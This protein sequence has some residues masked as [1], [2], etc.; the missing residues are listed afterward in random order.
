M[1]RASERT[2]DAAVRTTRAGPYPRD[3]V[4]LVIVEGMRTVTGG[5][6]IG[7]ALSLAAGRMIE[8]LLYGIKP[9]DP[10]VIVV[11]A[12]LL[13]GVA[14]VAAFAPAWHAARVDPVTA[15]R[16]E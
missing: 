2:T 8:S 5:V 10:G 6:V 14:A 3:V 15:L 1:T 7:I 13:L 9:S 11:V 16:M 12:V 4:R